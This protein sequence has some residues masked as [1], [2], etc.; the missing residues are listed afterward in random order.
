MI[1]MIRTAWL[2]LN[3][4]D[5]QHSENDDQHSENDG[6]HSEND[7]WP[8]VGKHDQSEDVDK[9]QPLPE[10]PDKGLL[11]HLM[12]EVEGTS[13]AHISLSVLLGAHDK[14]G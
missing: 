8:E 14:E 6:Q 9:V 12:N 11:G 3:E 7:G 13:P 10:H 5:D 4:N 2:A 1:L